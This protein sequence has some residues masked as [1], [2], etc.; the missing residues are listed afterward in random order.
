MT[1]TIDHAR[2]L[3]DIV[4]RIPHED[5]VGLA[6]MLTAQRTGH[7][8]DDL[9]EVPLALSIVERMAEI[10]EVT[11]ISRLQTFLASLG[12]DHLDQDTEAPAMIAAAQAEVSNVV[13]IRAD[14]YSDE[15]TAALLAASIDAWCAEAEAAGD[16]AA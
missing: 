9:D 13:P 15:A 5:L 7:T 3:E 6:I 14:I 1:I 4:I 10:D 12:C 16:R 8:F 2:V 11:G